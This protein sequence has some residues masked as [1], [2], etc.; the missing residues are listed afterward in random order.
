MNNII[1]ICVHAFTALFGVNLFESRPIVI[2]ALSTVNS[3][4]AWV[5]GVILRVGF[6]NLSL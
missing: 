3:L 6:K 4:V 1:N 2:C 5:G